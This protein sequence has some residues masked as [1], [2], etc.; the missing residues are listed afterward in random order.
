[1]RKTLDTSFQKVRVVAQSDNV[2][3]FC[4][5]C[6]FF[7]AQYEALLDLMFP[8]FFVWGLGYRLSPISAD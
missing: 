2:V 8:P 7:S 6:S 3:L 4:C 1:M 5:L